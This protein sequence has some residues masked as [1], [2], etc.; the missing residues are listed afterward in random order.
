MQMHHH[1]RSRFLVD[2][3]A[4]MGF[5]FSYSEVQRFEENSA[6]SV[7]PDVLGG[8]IN[9]LDAALLF[10]ADNVDHNIITLDGK[11]T[12]HGMGIIAD[13]TPGR[14]TSHTVLRQKIAQL[15]I[16][17]LAQVD[18][19]EYRFA[20][21]TR[22]NIK[23]DPMPY[24]DGDAHKIDIL[25]AMT[26]RFKKS[27][28][29]WQGMMHLLHKDCDHPEQFSVVFLPII[30]MYPGDKSCIFSTLEYLCFLANGHK[31]TAV[32]T[33]D[34]P[35]YWKASEIK[36]EVPGDSQIRSVVFLLGSFY[37]LM[38]LLGAIGTLMDGSGIKEILG[39]IYGENAVQHI[40]TGKAVQR[41]LRGH[42][43]LDQ[44]LT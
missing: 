6:A 33:F 39:T 24:F 38:N 28:P 34:Q 42:L 18:I 2:T 21:Y 3:M 25:R 22:N 4:A 1:F 29:G 17:D 9:A 30:D 44:C 35:L 8:D 19:K 41:A 32:V 12:F 14:Q 31:T 15:K 26:F 20:K 37:T 43:H 36:H 11:G 16:V 23:F 10:A 27:A 7:A 5:S 40:M 13:I